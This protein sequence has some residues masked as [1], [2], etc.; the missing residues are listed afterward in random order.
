ME[1]I[2]PAAPSRSR[3][4][5]I[6][7]RRC[8]RQ[9]NCPAA[10]PGSSGASTDFLGADRDRGIRGTDARPWPADDWGC[11][12][13]AAGLGSAASTGSPEPTADRTAARTP[14]LSP[15]NDWG[16]ICPA[17]CLGAAASTL[18]AE[19]GRDGRAG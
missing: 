4:C 9:S 10:G 13:P 8:L 1:P 3:H 11:I 7:R 16:C 2:A 6:L 17:D 19:G 12:C 5:P 18:G 14:A 15:G